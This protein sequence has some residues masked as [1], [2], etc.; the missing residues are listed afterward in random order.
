LSLCSRIVITSE[1]TLQ[2]N[3]QPGTRRLL[4]MSGLGWAML[5]GRSDV[6]IARVVQRTNSRLASGGQCVDADEVARHVGRARACSYAFSRGTVSEGVGVVG[7][8]LPVGRAGERLVV[9]VGGLL[10]RLEELLAEIV[11]SLQAHLSAAAG[12]A[13]QA[14]H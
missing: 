10:G 1:G 7:V 13:A 5:S 11:R 3:V 2:F 6:E 14:E 8:A 9:R 4:C 12:A